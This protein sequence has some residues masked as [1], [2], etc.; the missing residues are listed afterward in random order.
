VPANHWWGSPAKQTGI[1]LDSPTHAAAAK[2]LANKLDW[3]LEFSLVI[4]GTIFRSGAFQSA[5]S[6]KSLL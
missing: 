4:I 6:L 3:S 2:M 5:Q 1:E